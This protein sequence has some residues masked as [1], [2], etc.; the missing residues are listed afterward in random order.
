MLGC[1]G[2]SKN[3]GAQSDQ[4]NKQSI[5]DEEHKQV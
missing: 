4:H 3:G 5:M 2:A 1:K